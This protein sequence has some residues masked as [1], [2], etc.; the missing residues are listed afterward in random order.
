MATKF[1]LAAWESHTKL[2][3]FVWKFPVQW[4]IKIQKLVSTKDAKRLKYFFV[5]EFGILLEVILDSLKS[6][7]NPLF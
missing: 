7:Q 1:R 6:C 4:D 2:N 5:C 3:E